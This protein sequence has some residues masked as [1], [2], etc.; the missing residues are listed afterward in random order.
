MR[1]L[2]I[3]TTEQPPQR[4]YPSPSIRR[5]TINPSTYQQAIDIALPPVVAHVIAGRPDVA[6]SDL[7][8]FLTA[9]VDDLDPWSGL[10]DID[11]SARRLADALKAREIIGI[12]TDYDMDG[13]GAHAVFRSVLINLFGHP[14]DRL[15]SYVGHRLTDGYGLCAP[16][17][18]RIVAD[19]PRPTLLV[20]A[21]CGSTDEERI[22]QLRAAHVEVIVTDHHELPAEGPPRS[23][24]A[25]INPQ[26]T[27]CAYPDKAIAGGM[28]LWLL[29]KATQDKL[30]RQGHRGARL[31]D[32]GGVMDYVACSTVADC[33]SL[34]SQNN[35]AVVRRGLR[36]IERRVRPCWKALGHVIGA[37]GVVRA[38]SIAF[39]IAPRINARSRLADPF[40]A[41]HFLLASDLP[42]ATSWASVLETENQSRKK[43]EL[44][45]IE[46]AL[47]RAADQVD[48]G[49]ASITLVLPDGHP[50]VQGICSARLVETFGRPTF[51]FSPSP[52]EAGLLTGS[53]RSI[54]GV[55]VRTLLQRVADVQPELVHR[56]GGHKAAAGATIRE[57]HFPCFEV[58]FERFARE[59]V[60]LRDLGPMRWSDGELSVA[61]LT[62]ATLDALNVLEPTG[63]GFEPPTFDGEFRIVEVGPIGDG[64]HLRL[65]LGR[66]RKRWQAVWFRARRSPDDPLPVTAGQCAHFLYRLR[67]NSFRGERKF[68]LQIEAVFDR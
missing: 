38:E 19:S 18:Q 49:R 40:A 16:V 54:D 66:E 9:D 27:D 33:V 22:A 52:T 28:V 61:D 32:L 8:R 21:D 15:S 25:C 45:M 59:S 12:Q 41:L 20:T 67:D 46:M 24:F 6:D 62:L 14:P 23:A 31:A 37:S 64:R 63:R 7:I 57:G 53:A 65:V 10:A 30:I 1:P 51:L 50:G 39:G 5:R 43:I 68:R 58:L 60:S 11:E 26:R 13:L 47:N 4:T 17:A 55:N 2:S 44:A 29:M 34:A 36:R 56:F 48:A 3:A 42:M 35:R